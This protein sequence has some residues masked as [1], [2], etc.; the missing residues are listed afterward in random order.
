MA[1]LLA[2]IAII[3]TM[4]ALLSFVTANADAALAERYAE[5][6]RIRYELEKK[7]NLFLDE[8]DR[9]VQNGKIPER[10]DITEKGDGIYS[11]T[12]HEGDYTLSV[13]F[14]ITDGR[15]EVE[16]WKISRKWEE[17]GPYLDVWQP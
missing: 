17:A 9:E 10:D 15:C 11:H 14:K 12:E 5:V 7:G 16:R 13:D 8:L 4:L 2:I 6:V 1:I 3:L